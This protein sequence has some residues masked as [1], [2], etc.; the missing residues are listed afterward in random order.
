MAEQLWLTERE[1]RAWRGFL[2]MH[3][4]VSSALQRELQRDTG[5][6]YPDYEVLVYLSEAPGGQMRPFQL[7]DALQWEKSRLSHQLRRMQDRGLVT[8]EDCESDRRGA[9]VTITGAGWAAIRAAAPQ[10]VRQ[11]RRAFLA[12]LTPG[13]LDALTEIADA[14]LGR[15]A[16]SPGGGDGTGPSR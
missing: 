4:E 5:L 14:V 13:Q 8:R 9:V 10:H 15:L 1:Q 12:A 3:A 2:R 11:V 6:S 16:V 7:G